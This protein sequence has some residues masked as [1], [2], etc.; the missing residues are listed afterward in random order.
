MLWLVVYLALAGMLGILA[1]LS[2]KEKLYTR[3]ELSTAEAVLRR[4]A[5]YLY[6]RVLYRGGGRGN[7]AGGFLSAG[8]ILAERVQ[9]D[10]CVLHPAAKPEGEMARH[11]IRQLQTMLTFLLAADLLGIAVWSSER[12]QDAIR[13][14]GSIERPGYEEPALTVIAKAEADTQNGS[15]DYGE[16]SIVV[17]SRK[18][19]VEEAEKMAEQAWEELEQK[20]T[21]DN[22]GL[23]YVTENLQ[24]MRSL[25]D[26][27]F[28]ISWESSNY[29][30]VDGDGTV[31]S[32]RLGQGEHE[33]VQLTATLTYEGNSWS[34]SYELMIFPRRRNGE[35]A[36]REKISAELEQQETGTAEKDVFFLPAVINGTAV[37]WAQVREE[38][39]QWVFVLILAAGGAAAFGMDREV[40]QRVVRRDRELALDY[41]LIISKITLFLGAGMSIRNIFMRLGEDYREKRRRGGEK[42]YVYEEIVL[43][44]R[45]LE[46]GIPETSAYAAF[47]RRCHA[48]QYAKL[49]ALL[50]ASQMKGNDALL[51]ALQEE[52]DRSFEERRG[53]AR[54][55]GEEAGTKLLLPMLMMLGITLVIIMIPAYFSFSL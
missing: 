9:Q 17:S 50:A 10:L 3:K 11:R 44:C 42:R 28:Q 40:H 21:V 37:R 19:T 55:M 35:E 49:G 47:G 15:E 20:I 53:I 5:V 6:R 26:Y 8:G 43:V 34:R 14:D 31:Y 7:R 48:R 30:M 13:P 23:H 4:M 24:L 12:Q 52:A 46:S 32:D 54:Q 1:L 25:P 51:K 18:Y 38:T 16:Y 36:L 2:R 39:D 33:N 41:P 45:E 22:Q 29:S 27:P